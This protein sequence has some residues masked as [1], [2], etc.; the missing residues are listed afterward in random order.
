MAAVTSHGCTFSWN[1]SAVTEVTSISMSASKDTY[2]VTDL[3]DTAYKQ[4]IAGLSEAECTIEV[5]YDPSAHDNFLTGLA[6][7]ATAAT[8]I[9]FEDGGS[10]TTFTFD[11]FLT[12]FDPSA[13]TGSQLTAS[14]SFKATGTVTEA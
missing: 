9:T 11:A 10:D 4:F 8:V 7:G 3:D 1:G 6:S 13:S 12:G 2:E 5:N 14:V